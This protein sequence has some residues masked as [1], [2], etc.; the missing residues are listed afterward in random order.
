MIKF[1]N[2]RL[3]EG[4]RDEINPPPRRRAGRVRGFQGAK[5]GVSFGKENMKI[6]KQTL[7]KIKAHGITIAV[8]VILNVLFFLMLKCG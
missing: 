6:N 2:F 1:T 7:A 3:N 5:V 4:A 8:M